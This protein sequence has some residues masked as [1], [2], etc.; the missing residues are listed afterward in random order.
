MPTLSE[1]Y[2]FIYKDSDFW[3]RCVIAILKVASDVL[4]ESP[5]TANHAIRLTWANEALVDP[6]SKFKLLKYKIAAN[7]TIV[8]KGETA[9][10]AEIINAVSNV[11]AAVCV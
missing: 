11:V 2:N 4:T 6:E 3:R 5:A 9:T 1:Y 7:S 8:S 10:D